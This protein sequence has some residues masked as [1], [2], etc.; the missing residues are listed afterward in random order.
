MR[1]ITEDCVRLTGTVHTKAVVLYWWIGE[2]VYESTYPGD[3]GLERGRRLVD[4]VG[5]RVPGS[6]RRAVR[7]RPDAFLHLVELEEPDGRHD[8]PQVDEDTRTEPA[9]GNATDRWVDWWMDGGWVG[10]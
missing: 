1:N 4:D 8:V 7:L 3:A 2:Q 5:R 10:E 6:A 9:A